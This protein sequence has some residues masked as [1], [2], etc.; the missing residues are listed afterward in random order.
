MVLNQQV[1]DKSHFALGSH[2]YVLRTVWRNRTGIANLHFCRPTAR[3][4][5]CPSGSI[6]THP[7]FV[8]GAPATWHN[9]TQHTNTRPVP[10]MLTFPTPPKPPFPSFT[11]DHRSFPLKVSLNR[12]PAWQSTPVTVLARHGDWLDARHTVRSRLT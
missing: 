2:A 1:I 12:K 7:P 11:L 8:E 10:I 3:P 5:F 9:S 6:A 4:Q